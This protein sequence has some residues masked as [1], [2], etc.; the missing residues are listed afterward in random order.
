MCD[1]LQ[2]S[3]SPDP[4]HNLK[5]SA[6]GGFQGE[7]SPLKIH[8]IFEEFGNLTRG[9]LA[10]IKAVIN[11]ATLMFKKV[12]FADPKYLK[13]FFFLANTNELPFPKN[14]SKET[15]LALINL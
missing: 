7:F 2:E 10:D 1:I 11:N 5:I 8:N 9:M 3:V 13:A 12:K 4:E 14:Q 15:Y 6:N